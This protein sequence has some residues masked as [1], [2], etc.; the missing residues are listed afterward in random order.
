MGTQLTYVAVAARGSA[1]VHIL[2]FKHHDCKFKHLYS[3]NMEPTM[4]NPEQ[5]ELNADQKYSKFPYTVNL[6]LDC[7][8]LAVT[9]CNG[10]VKILKMPPVLSPMDAKSTE[11]VPAQ[12][13]P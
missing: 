10:E 3:F 2:V 13:A 7:A 8:F 12:A 5:P 6:S 9:L 4:A 11:A 1:A